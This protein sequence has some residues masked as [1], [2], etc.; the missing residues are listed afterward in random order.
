MLFNAKVDFHLRAGPAD[1]TATDFIVTTDLIVESGQQPNGW[2][3]VTVYPAEG[4]TK[5]G[6]ALSDW[7][8]PL[9]FDSHIDE[10]TFAEACT[11]AA[12]QFG[13]NAYYLYAVAMV[14]SGIKNTPGNQSSAFGPFQI[15]ADTWTR[16][17]AKGKL[18]LSGVDRFKPYMQPSVAALI[19]AEGMT[20]LRSVLQDKRLPTPAELYFGYLFGTRG[21][22]VILG[23]NQQISIRNALLKL[24]DGLAAKADEVIAAN[25][26]LLTGDDA[27]TV[28]VVL[29][30]V[31]KKLND[32]LK[33]V[34]PDTVSNI[35]ES[36]LSRELVAKAVS[37]NDTF[38]VVEKFDD[39]SG[40]Q[41]LLKQTAGQQSEVVA[42]DTKV[43]PVV[44]SDKVPADVAAKLNKAV[45]TG[46]PAA[47]QGPVGP[48]PQP[49][50][51]LSEIVLAK[52]RAC[53]GTLVTK[54]VSGTNHGRVACAWAVN[55]VVKEALGKPVGGGLSTSEM[56]KVLR[57]N[58]S[59]LGDA[60]V[61]GGAIVISPTTGSNVG[62]VGIVGSISAKLGDTVIYSNSS[63]KGVFSHAFTIDTWKR[64]Y[65]QK[66]GLPVLFYALNPNRF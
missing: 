48:P 52:A 56:G 41:F 37:G 62:H 45:E 23:G 53:D 47:P 50:H 54:N 3:P 5:N 4:G 32:A 25:A 2:T 1:D 11:E 15:L 26:P 8:A 60:E 30:E 31:G 42:A 35:A 55:E 66:K 64:H 16:Y 7:L 49:G 38:W 57:A 51:S 33:E 58:D 29:N 18:G 46:G 65:N 43:L 24:Y 6:F 20:E 44:P 13:T 12:R 36:D 40:G 9:V 61:M 17:V 28:A 34:L 63:S 27:R 39:E 10:D 19:A 14:E 22:Q 21:A 59:P